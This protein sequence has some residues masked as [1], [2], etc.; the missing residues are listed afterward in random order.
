MAFFKPE[1]VLPEIV[2]PE[3]YQ[4]GNQVE[5]CRARDCDAKAM[6][7]LYNKWVEIGARVP[8]LQFTTVSLVK[9]M[10]TQLQINGYP[11]W[12]FWVG[13]VIVGWCALGPFGWGGSGTLGT[14]DLSIYVLPEWVGAGLGA[15]AVFLAYRRRH[16]LGFKSVAV[17]VLKVNNTSRNL[18]RGI[19]LQCWGNLPAL[20]EGKEQQ[21]DVE[22]WGCHLDNP[23]W[24]AH[25]DRLAVRLER[26]LGGWIRQRYSFESLQ[27]VEAA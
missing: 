26:R 17:W 14:V 4:L 13:E 20:V 9:S 25:M 11:V 15:Q 18:A 27:Q 3:R 19:G 23:D 6:A 24:C 10:L 21:H 7:A 12:C 16:V 1:V 8:G 2:M 22:I 5:W